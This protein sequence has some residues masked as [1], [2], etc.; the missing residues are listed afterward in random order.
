MDLGVSAS[1]ALYVGALAMLAAV[2]AGILPAVQATGSLMR[3]GLRTLGI[4]GGVQ[5]GKTWSAMV[6]VQVALAVL[7]LPL[8]AE[9]GWG[10]LR[11]SLVGPGFAAEE[12]MT[13]RVQ[14]FGPSTTDYACYRGDDR[15]REP[16]RSRR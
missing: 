9:L 2:I 15:R 6:V 14:L 16:P 13:A 4:G 3:S 5:L 8:A 1:S 10:L 7:I 12:Y 11:P